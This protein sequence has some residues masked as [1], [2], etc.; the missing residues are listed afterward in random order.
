MQVY[1]RVSS[2]EP[3]PGNSFSRWWSRAKPLLGTQGVLGDISTCTSLPFSSARG[4]R[5]DGRQGLCSWLGLP[6]RPG[7]QT[8]R[9]PKRS[10]SNRAWQPTS[11]WECHSLI[12]TWP[13]LPGQSLGC[14]HP[15]NSKALLEQADTHTHT[16][17]HTRTQSTA[18]AKP[19]PTFNENKSLDILSSQFF[20]DLIIQIS[21]FFGLFK[22]R[23]EW[24][25]SLN[26]IIECHNCFLH[27]C[28]NVW[29]K[30]CTLSSP[31][32]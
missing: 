8:C 17:T 2:T 6:G 11:K 32:V 30:L 5:E 28:T 23:E 22:E 3:S 16:H 27:F 24:L 21:A 15:G 14:D 31:T 4:A 12:R 7:Q 19:P 13:Y 20:T 18:N 26:G 10:S 25:I 1:A 29:V 9:Q